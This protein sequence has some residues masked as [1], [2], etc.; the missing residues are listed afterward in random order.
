M[1]SLRNGSIVC[2]CI[3]SCPEVLGVALTRIRKGCLPAVAVP[4]SDGVDEGFAASIARQYGARYRTGMRS[5][6]AMVRS[7]TLTRYRGRKILVAQKTAWLGYPI[8]A[9]R[10]RWVEHRPSPLGRSSYKS[11]THLKRFPLSWLSY[12][13]YQNNVLKTEIY[14]HF[15]ATGLLLG[16]VRGTSGARFAFSFIDDEAKLHGRGLSMERGW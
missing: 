2:V 9:N 5:M 11:R 12:G 1:K 16:V 3:R 4:V 13:F 8:L 6:L 14:R 10:R 7:D 15:A